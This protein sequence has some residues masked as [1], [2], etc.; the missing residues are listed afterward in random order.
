[1]GGWRKRGLWA[2]AALEGFSGG[3][4][5]RSLRTSPQ[6]SSCSLGSIKL[7]RAGLERCPDPV[8]TKGGLRLLMGS[9]STAAC[10]P[11]ASSAPATGVFRA[12]C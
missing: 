10:H 3:R 4:V 12:H 1:M 2:Q 7:E 5:R 6:S 8:T 9:A 11:L